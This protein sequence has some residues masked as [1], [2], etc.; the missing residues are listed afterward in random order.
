MMGAGI[1]GGVAL[2]AGA[3][4]GSQQA[5]K[6]KTAEKNRKKE[7]LGIQGGMLADIN[8]S[9][10]DQYANI[11]KANKAST[12]GYGDAI[13]D[14]DRIEGQG[15]KQANSFFQQ[16]LGGADA[17]AAGR[18]LLGAS[19]NANMRLGAA[20]QASLY[21]TDAQIAASKLRTSAK[22][23]LGNAQAQGFTNLGN[24]HAY[25]AGRRNE[26]M[27]KYFDY[28]AGV[29]YTSQQPQLGGLGA[30]SQTFNNPYQ[31]PPTV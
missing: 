2:G 28:L 21:A 25:R 6:N 16:A 29:Q 4:A 24:F 10:A 30:L 19:G 14:A 1:A 11:L 7:L 31:T 27:G 15:L 8:Q 5:K 9:G 13:K 22:L 20:R 3:I 26:V 17:G 12:Q 23:G 18:G